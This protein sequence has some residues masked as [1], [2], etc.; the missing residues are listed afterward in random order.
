MARKAFLKLAQA[1][2]QIVLTCWAFAGFASC[3]AISVP[4]R[5]EAATANDH[6]CTDSKDWIGVGA[7]WYDCAAAIGKLRSTD[8]HQYGD[9]ELEF[10]SYR[11]KAR[12]KLARQTP[13]KYTFGR[14]IFSPY[15]EET[16]M[17]ASR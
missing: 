17:L 11:T 6:F 14:E 9:R 7:A 8:T 2:I 16:F 12:S 10:F 3:I 5:T 13:I 1:L 4:S 15:D